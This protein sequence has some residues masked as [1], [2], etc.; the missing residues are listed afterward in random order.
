MTSKDIMIGWARK[1]TYK[2]RN[3]YRI[4][5]KKIKGHMDEGGQM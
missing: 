5:V 3:K 1:N 4:V 2:T